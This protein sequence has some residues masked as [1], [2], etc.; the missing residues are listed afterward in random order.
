[1]DDSV[2]SSIKKN[3]NRVEIAI[4]LKGV[5]VKW[6]YCQNYFHENSLN[7]HLLIV[8]KGKDLKEKTKVNMFYRIKKRRFETIKKI[9]KDLEEHRK[10]HYYQKIKI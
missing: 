2:E 3:K 5:K 1:M 7:N 9:M 6:P 10:K 8:H 4:S